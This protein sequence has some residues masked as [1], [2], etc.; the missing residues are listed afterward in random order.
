MG[1][2]SVL[3][4][5]GVCALASV[6]RG[7]AAARVDFA[8]DV[9]PILLENCLQCHGPRQQRNGF[10]LDRRRDAMRGGT[11]P[12][13][14]PGNSAGSRLFQRLIGEHYGT[15]MPPSGPLEAGEIA[16]LRAWIDQGASWPDELANDVTPPP[17]DPGASRLMEAMRAGDS[18][19]WRAMLPEALDHRGPGGSTPLMY[20]V[21]YA[22]AASVRLLLDGGANASAANDAGATA[23]MWAAGEPEKARLLLERGA[24]PNARSNDG[25]TALLIAAGH[26][27]NLETV[28]RLLDR[29]AS[30]VV[31]GTESPLVPAAGLGDEA[32]MRLLIDRGADPAA[33]GP[34]AMVGAAAARCAGCLDLLV[35]P[36]GKT[37][38]AV[39]K[40][41]AAELNR[42]VVFL[43]PPFGDGRNVPALLE[44]GADPGAR[45]LDGHTLL[46]L[47]ASS[48][49]LPLATVRALVERGAD[50]NARGPHGE[51]ALAFAGLRGHT[52][53]VDLLRQEG[54]RESAAGG[55]AASAPAAGE[56]VK[57]ARSAGEAVR[58]ALPLL[59]TTSATFLRKSG[60]VSCH[61]NTLTAM[62]VATARSHGLAVDESI[63]REQLRGT[64]AFL[65]DWRERV[66]QGRGIPGQAATVGPLLL[67]LAAQGHPPDLATDAMARYLL[68]QQLPDGSWR[69][70]AHRP[71]SGSSAI[72]I[73]AS[74]LR[75]LRAYGPEAQRP[76]CQ[77][78]I[79]RAT[80][81]LLTVLP[82]TSEDQAYLLLGLG[83]AGMGPDHPAVRRAVREALAAQR[84]DGGWAQM[85]SLPSDAYA[86]GQ[87]LFA[88]R[89]GG[90]L[91]A[92]DPAVGRGI[93]HLLATQGADGSWHVRS[94]AIPLQ[95]YF[96][97]GFPHGPDQWISAA[98]TGWAAMAL[99]SAAPA[100][101][102]SPATAARLR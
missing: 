51:T 24:D 69:R 16:T 98:A 87:V 18:G 2:S 17:P 19:R 73:T 7:E 91:A 27:N 21:L 25:R 65:E 94:R 97:S 96:E 42:A 9:R 40:A 53:L 35:G 67:G 61:H 22:D 34:M 70:T 41:K 49:L 84:P 78:A 10:R 59:Q 32:V 66:L 52:P 64:A 54:A 3:I 80:A 76:R 6:A 38:S 100:P 99:A 28:K 13:I 31:K 8:R 5:L 75:A 77:A 92:A 46:M 88:L 36:D 93:R 74:A 72:Q 26:R 12:V 29:G 82:T 50:V 1:K 47:A 11:I 71:P 23:L 63:A 14:G 68:D 58:R 62:A 90:G 79:A 101:A 102:P 45:D 48:D 95:P 83:W 57:A 55:T 86:T 30:P 37:T 20:A 43:A 81:W 33:A 85:A 15:R 44:R 56:S 4:V 60:C 89:E 39:G